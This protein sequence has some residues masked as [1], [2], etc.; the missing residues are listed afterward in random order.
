MHKKVIF[1]LTSL[2]L[3]VNM[4]TKFERKKVQPPVWPGSL[5]SSRICGCR[6]EL[7]GGDCVSLSSSSL[8][9][10]V[11]FVPTD[12]EAGCVSGGTASSTACGQKTSR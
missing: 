12:G 10:R 2:Q 11:L 8:V 4:L 9:G 3:T 1:I 5:L 7:A 6:R